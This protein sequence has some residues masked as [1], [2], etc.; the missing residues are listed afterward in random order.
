LITSRQIAIRRKEKMNKRSK[1]LNATTVTNSS[2]RKREKGK[3][4]V[5]EEKDN[6]KGN[7]VRLFMTK[8]NEN[9]DASQI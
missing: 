5:V 3:T 9:S 2:M 8:T 6:E 1:V 7:E 4:N